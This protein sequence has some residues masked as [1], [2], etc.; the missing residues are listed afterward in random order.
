M[1]LLGRYSNQA[2]VLA[3]LSN[4]LALPTR[5]T[6]ALPRRVRK[7]QHRLTDNEQVN[8]VAAYNAGRTV[9]QLAEQF[10]TSRQTVSSVLN[11]HG[12]PR[13][14]RTISA[15]E[16]SIASQLYK[17]GLS[18]ARIGKRL[19]M[20]AGTIHDA[21]RKVGI[22]MRPVGTNQWRART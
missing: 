19:E 2:R 14:R 12:I 13:G 15:D 4:L 6:P 7:Q 21:L 3:E 18:L 1:E 11:K 20:D 17:D 5:Q 10:C 9:Q 16:I 8:L 22:K